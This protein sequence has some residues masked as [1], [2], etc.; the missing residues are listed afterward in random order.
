MIKVMLGVS[1]QNSFS[2]ERMLVYTITRGFYSYVYHPKSCDEIK[3]INKC[4]S[5][6]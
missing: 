2:W 6:D 3:G 4:A 1:V 5:T